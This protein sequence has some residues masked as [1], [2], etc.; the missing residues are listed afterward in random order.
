MLHLFLLKTPKPNLFRTYWLKK[1]FFNWRI[2]ALQNFVVFC[3]TSTRISHRYSRVP[4]FLTSLPSPSSAHS[5]V[6][7]RAPVWVAWVIQQIP[8]GY[9]FHIWYCRFLCYSLHASHLLPP[10]LP[11]C[12]C[13][14]CLAC[15]LASHFC[16]GYVCLHQGGVALIV[17]LCLSH[18]FPY[19]AALIL[20]VKFSWSMGVQ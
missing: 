18:M 6:C 3:P 17:V 19:G 16:D 2:I 10:L 7:Y 5:L 8:V 1:I 20:G 14:P 9:L 12:P 13:W 11:L 4:S 15:A